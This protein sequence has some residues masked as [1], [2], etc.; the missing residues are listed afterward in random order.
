LNALARSFFSGTACWMTYGP[1]P[2]PP[3]TVPH[4]L[5]A[6]AD[7]IDGEQR[8]GGLTTLSLQRRLDRHL[9]QARQAARGKTPTMGVHEWLLG[10]EA[11]GLKPIPKAIKT[12]NTRAAHAAE[13]G[14]IATGRQLGFDLLN[15]MTAGH[16][17]WTRML[18]SRAHGGRPIA[19]EDGRVF[20]SADDAARFQGISSAGVSAVLH[21]RC[22]RFKRHTFRYMEL[23]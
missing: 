7:P 15:G 14:L 12:Y 23:K 6:L 17:H 20:A 22:K 21:G 18:M 2:G 1:S 8:Y 10:L 16:S 4:Q 19:D 5:Y 9:V 13:G 11:R 3:H